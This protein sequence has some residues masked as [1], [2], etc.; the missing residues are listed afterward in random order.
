MIDHA[1]NAGLLP[2]FHTHSYLSLCLGV[3]VSAAGCERTEGIATRSYS[4]QQA[5][6]VLKQNTI[7]IYPFSSLHLSIPPSYITF[8]LY[9]SS[10]NFAPTCSDYY[11][12][13]LL[14]FRFSLLSIHSSY[15]CS[16]A[17]HHTF[18]SEFFSTLTMHGFPV[19]RH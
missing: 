10:S 16:L 19:R 8:L 14:L 3:S 9:A 6:N 5:S 17:L 12:F 13:L 18:L 2:T 15:A 1:A 7:F 11:P 4:A